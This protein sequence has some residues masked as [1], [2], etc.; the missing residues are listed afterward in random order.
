M[1]DY[2]PVP[3]SPP[4][5]KKDV[6]TT[7]ADDPPSYQSPPIPPAFLCAITSEMMSDPVVTSDGQTYERK[8][9]EVIRVSTEGFI[10]PLALCSLS[11]VVARM[12]GEG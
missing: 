7:Q 10:E 6:A 8:A 11:S 5:S 9:I 12:D 2:K 1:A 4:Q 3:E